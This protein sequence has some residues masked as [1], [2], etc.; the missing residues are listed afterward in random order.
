[1]AN[2]EGFIQKIRKSEE[3]LKKKVK[4][5]KLNVVADK[6]IG[7]FS[8][9]DIQLQEGEKGTVH[10]PNVKELLKTDTFGID[11]Y[12]F[13]N[14]VDNGVKIGVQP[15]IL[16]GLKNRIFNIMGRG[17]EVIS[18]PNVYHENYGKDFCTTNLDITLIAK[19]DYDL[20]RISTNEGAYI[21]QRAYDE[22]YLQDNPLN[23]RYSREF[24]FGSG[25]KGDV[26]KLCGSEFY[27]AV[28]DVKIPI[29][30]GKIIGDTNIYVN[31]RFMVAPSGS[32]RIRVEFYKLINK[33]IE[34]GYGNTDTKK[35]YEDVGIGFNGIVEFRHISAGGKF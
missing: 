7:D 19:G 9:T 23:V 21:E 14:T 26:I 28:N 18:I 11:E 13:M 4:N 10:T 8:I 6:F 27:A 25:K 22:D 2:F 5:I 12:E 17:H 33:T 24:F 15:R 29:R 3:N 30:N 20:L 32:F 34:N 1:M 35:V 16:K 31:Q